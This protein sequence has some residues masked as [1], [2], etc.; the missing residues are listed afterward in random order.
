LEA[1]IAL[2]TGL[3]NQNAKRD[4][5]QAQTSA[6]ARVYA[7]DQA[8]RAAIAGPVPET[9]LKAFPGPPMTLGSA[10]AAHLTLI[11]WCKDCRDLVEPDPAGRCARSAD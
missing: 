3:G 6:G 7:A 10:A 4:P 2:L 9:P 8:I 1:R 11:V 5:R